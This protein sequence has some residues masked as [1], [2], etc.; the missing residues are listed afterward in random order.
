MWFP[1]ACR[2]AGQYASLYGYLWLFSVARCALHCAAGRWRVSTHASLYGCLV[3]SSVTLGGPVCEIKWLVVVPSS[4]LR[5]Q[6][7]PVC[8]QVGQNESLY[9]YLLPP[10][11]VTGQAKPAAISGA[12]A[13]EVWV[14]PSFVGIQTALESTA[15][16]GESWPPYLTFD[17][18]WRIFYRH[19]LQNSRKTYRSA[20]V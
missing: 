17:E 6:G 1:P 19:Y 5:A 13:H 2:R 15:L 16:L 14:P 11:L 7:G 12:C 9:G 20:P 10:Q 4:V 8:C 3:P 18:I